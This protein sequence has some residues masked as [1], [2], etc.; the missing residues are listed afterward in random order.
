MSE[1]ILHQAFLISLAGPP[2]CND[3]LGEHF[4]RHNGFVIPSK[5]AAR[6]AQNIPRGIEC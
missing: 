5:G 1:R 6:S 2:Q 4:T 3:L